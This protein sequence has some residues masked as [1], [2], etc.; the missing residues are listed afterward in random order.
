MRLLEHG[1]GNPAE[2]AFV[3]RR[4][5]IAA[6]YHQIDRKALCRV[7]NCTANVARLVE[8]TRLF[9]VNAVSVQMAGQCRQ[10]QRAIS[11]GLCADA[12]MYDVH[13]LCGLQERQRVTHSAGGLPRAAL[14]NQNALAQ[15]AHGFPARHNENGSSGTEQG[16]IQHRVVERGSI[17]RNRLSN[18]DHI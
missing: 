8:H 9:D 5:A 7:Q 3:K 12:D 17:G 13:N 1:A 16:S 10:G 4:M 14:G 18:D 6:H 11:L 2:N 15:T